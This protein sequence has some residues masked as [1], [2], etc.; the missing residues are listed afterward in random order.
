[1]S[2]SLL[3]TPS[4]GE[5]KAK[6]EGNMPTVEEVMEFSFKKVLQYLTRIRKSQFKNQKVDVLIRELN[7][8]Y[9]K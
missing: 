2:T 7:P 1:M 4:V 9:A 3:R 8:T 5:I 6:K